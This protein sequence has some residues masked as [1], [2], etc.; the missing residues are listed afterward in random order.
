MIFT[1]LSAT[2][3]PKSS[4]T[5]GPSHGSSLNDRRKDRMRLRNHTLPF[6]GVAVLVGAGLGLC[7]RYSEAIV[8]KLSI[9]LPLMA[10]TQVDSSWI[11]DESW[12]GGVVFWLTI[13]LQWI[14]I[15][16]MA[17]LVFS[18]LGR[19]RRNE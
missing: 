1:L 14:A 17:S 13:I 5:N 15:G 18:G 6:V 8:V 11:M 19:K 2:K 7:S 16:W 12:Q 9:T 4:L 10:A 3:S